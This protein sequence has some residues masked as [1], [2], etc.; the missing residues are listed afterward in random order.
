MGDILFALYVLFWIIILVCT[1]Y[2]YLKD[3]PSVA[4][5][6]WD[7]LINDFSFSSKEFYTLLTKELQSKGITGVRFQRVALK[8]GNIFSSRRE[9]LRIHWKEYHFDIC[10]APFGKGF[11]LSWWLVYNFS[12]LELFISYIPFFGPWLVKKLFTI[13]FYKIDTATMFMTFT[14]RSVLSVLDELTVE[15]GV[16]LIRDDER[17]PLL[18]NIFNR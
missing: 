1:I 5:S 6:T 9:Y 18:N 10:A 3:K 14:H 15:E 2:F 17:K 8:E 11:F 4:H 13:T 12:Y 16:P 7:H